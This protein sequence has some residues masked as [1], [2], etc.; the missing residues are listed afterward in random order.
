LI[1]YAGNKVYHETQ[2]Q[3]WWETLITSFSF[4]AQQPNSDPGHLNFRFPDHTQVDIYTQ[5]DS[6]ER[7]ISPPQRPLPTQHIA[8][9]KGGSLTSLGF[10][11]AIRVNRRLQNCV[12]DFT[13]T[14]IGQ[15]ISNNK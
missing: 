4:A 5:W 14:R 13:A 6:S 8:K 15:N 10:E 1:L 2:I 9:T 3:S 11:T 7:V 12:L